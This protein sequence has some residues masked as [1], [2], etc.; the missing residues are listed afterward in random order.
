MKPQFNSEDDKQN[1]STRKLPSIMIAMGADRVEAV[2]DEKHA[3]SK[4]FEYDFVLVK[5]A[6]DVE[7]F[8]STRKGDRP[9]CVHIPWVKQSLVAG[10]LLEI[11]DL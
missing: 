1:E 3:A 8:N 6:E 11:P 4:S 7:K 2:C 10:K 5:D 9:A